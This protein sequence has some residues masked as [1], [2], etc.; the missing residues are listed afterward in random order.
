[1]HPVSPISYIMGHVSGQYIICFLVYMI[2]S[3]CIAFWCVYTYIYRVWGVYR[4]VY[5]TG[6]YHIA[7]YLSDN[8]DTCGCNMCSYGYDMYFGYSRYY[9]VYI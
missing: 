1:M 2:C 3:I 9:I 6:M 8:I 7:D 5:P 4:I